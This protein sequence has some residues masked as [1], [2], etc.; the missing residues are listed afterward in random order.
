M[1]ASTTNCKKL[2]LGSPLAPILMCESH[3][4]PI[5]VICEDCDEFICGE[6]AKSNHRDHNWKTLTTAATQR[7]RGLLKFLKKIKEKNLPGIDEKLE[8]MSKQMKENKKL[9]D[10]EIE[11]L[12]MH[13]D[14]IMAR[15]TEIKKL[16]EK[17]L[18]DNLVKKNDQLNL[19]KSELEKKKRGIVDTV[20]FMEENNSTMSDYSLIDNLRE[21]TKMLSKLEVNRTNCEH[22]VRFIRGEIN[23][24]LL[25]S[26]IGKTTDLDDIGVT[27]I[28]SF[29]YGD[30]VIHILKALSEDQCY[31]SE[32]KSIKYTEKVNQQGKKTQQF[33]ILPNDMCVTGNGDV[34]FTDFDNNSISSLSPSGSVSTVISTHPLV[35]GGICQS[36][37]GGLL[38]TL[39]D[40]AP[41]FYKLE[42]HSRRLV[43]HITVKGDFIH[44]YEYQKDGHTRLFTWPLCVTQNSNSDICV[45]NSTSRTSGDLVILSPSGQVKSVYRGQNLTKNFNPTDVVCDS[46]CNILVTDCK[47]NQI[48]QL[49][50]DGEFL[51]FLL[52]ENED[53]GPYSMSLYKSTLWVGYWE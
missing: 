10:S 34:Y 26:L 28:N 30:E 53:D 44:D 20:E 23:D 41:D 2:S 6:C 43:R 32:N 7:K 51:K 38:V 21:L 52:T 31:V 25:K 9:C 33:G 45:V 4:L 50:P 47:N 35:P 36:V 49:S 8:K 14:E 39:R 40:N 29:Q 37:G 22:S 24:D 46:L 42:S 13:V 48:H 12:K 17:T 5:D 18:R 11:K 1:A 3:N 27:Q 15:L 19:M 16:H